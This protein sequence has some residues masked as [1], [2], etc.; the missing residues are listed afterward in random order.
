MKRKFTD[1]FSLEEPPVTSVVP[2]QPPA[3]PPPPIT[4]LPSSKNDRRTYKAMYLNELRLDIENGNR[5][6]SVESSL[7]LIEGEAKKQKP[8]EYQ[9][10]FFS[11]EDVQRTKDEI[12][13]LLDTK[14]EQFNKYV[15]DLKWLSETPHVSDFVQYKARRVLHDL[16]PSETPPTPPLPTVFPDGAFAGNDRRNDKASSL[17]KLRLDI[18]NGNRNEKV[19]RYL[20]LLE[21]DAIKAQEKKSLYLFYLFTEEEIKLTND[22]VPNC[23]ET[24]HEEFKKYIS[25]LEWF[26]EWFSK[27]KPNISSSVRRILLGLS[28]KLCPAKAKVTDTDD[29]I[30]LQEN[31]NKCTDNLVTKNLKISRENATSLCSALNGILATSDKRKIPEK[32]D[33]IL[34]RWFLEDSIREEIFKTMRSDQLCFIHDIDY[35]LDT[36][37]FRVSEHVGKNNT[38]HSKLDSIRYFNE[39][40]RP[41]KSKLIAIPIN[42]QAKIQ[43]WGHATVLIIDRTSEI[44][45]DGKEHIVIEHFDSSYAS[46]DSH[47]EEDALKLVKDMFGDRYTYEFIGQMKTCPYSIQSRLI[48]TKY[49]GTC[50]QFQLWYALKRL[51]EPHKPR[52]QVIEEIDTFLDK[53]VDGMVELIK[54]FQNLIDIKLMYSSDT[55][56][57]GE[58]NDRKFYR[59]YA[60]NIFSLT[61]MKPN[62]DFERVVDYAIE[63]D[64]DINIQT[65]INMNTFLHFAI[66]EKNENQ[67]KILIQKG[68]DVNKQNANGQTP[69]HLAVTEGLETIC[70]LLLENGAD[71]NSEDFQKDTPLQYAVYSKNKNIATL[72]LK[73]GAKTDLKN[74]NGTSPVQ[75]LPAWY[76]LLFGTDERPVLGGK[77]RT[78]RRGKS[79]L[80]SRK[81]AQRKSAR[82]R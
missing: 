72:L 54:T 78:K 21:S 37:E 74:N 27:N 63:N 10:Y 31:I 80:T 82:K 4:V 13:N 46:G 40:I 36:R 14:H 50:S 3:P 9:F 26:S 75:F 65:N 19:E 68:A 24:K 28:K 22:E 69:L 2:E 15:S 45:K 5:N 52:D 38:K 23:L 11:E 60:T 55:E 59:N 25:D 18:E 77:K 39:Q 48:N 30:K 56:V 53:G 33:K 32:F 67:A 57:T 43:G 76:K 51:L 47:F 35:Y 62:E 71:V 7:K 29:K 44:D 42:L 58:V 81:L 16:F 1:V 66:L 6:E 17:N 64:I 49:S 73:H 70:E 61:K 20:M 34:H 12:P 79:K 41:C 8:P